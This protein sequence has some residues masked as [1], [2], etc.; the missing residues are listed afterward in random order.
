[1]LVPSSNIIITAAEAVILPQVKR[2]FRAHKFRP[3]APRD[4]DIYIALLEQRLIGALR[5][6]HYDTDRLLR[7]MCIHKDFRGKGL[8]SYMLQQLEPVLCQAP[9]YC[10]PYEHLQ[11]F[12]QRA[13]FETISQDQAPA[14]IRKKYAA[15]RQKG[16]KILLMKYRR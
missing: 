14:G 12:Y 7:S 1:M 4:D 13:G 9:C 5:L 8:G 11:D 6:C 2:F 16:K 10:F 3:Q 15:Y